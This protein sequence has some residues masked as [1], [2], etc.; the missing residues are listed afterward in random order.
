M[1]GDRYAVLFVRLCAFVSADHGSRV[2]SAQ[3]N[4]PHRRK[5]LA[6]WGIFV[7]LRVL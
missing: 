4:K 5:V 7:F 1:Q 3:Q 6:L 2:F